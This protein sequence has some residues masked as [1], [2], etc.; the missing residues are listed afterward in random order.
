MHPLIKYETEEINVPP[1]WG[2]RIIGDCSED[3]VASLFNNENAMRTYQELGTRRFISV[4]GSNTQCE[5]DPNVSNTEVT[6]E[7]FLG[8]KHRVTHYDYCRSVTSISPFFWHQD[9]STEKPAIVILCNAL[10]NEFVEGA[11]LTLLGEPEKIAS[12]YID[13]LRQFNVENSKEQPYISIESMI[14]YYAE[15]SGGSLDWGKLWNRIL[16]AYRNAKYDPKIKA[17]IPFLADGKVTIN[18]YT[19]FAFDTSPKHIFPQEYRGG[20]VLIF[21]DGLSTHS[22]LSRT[23]VSNEINIRKMYPDFK[24]LADLGMPYLA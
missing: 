6:L 1:G 5:V 24:L 22:R 2:T 21:H 17:A 11:P 16:D 19:Q 23:P 12:I 9:S 13:P 10:G 18:D 8:G 14:D 3:I 20:D 7:E 15:I 4:S